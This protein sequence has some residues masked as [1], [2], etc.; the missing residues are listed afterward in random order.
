[1]SRTSKAPKAIVTGAAGFIGSNTVARLLSK[2][3]QVVAI[4]NLSR[5]GAEVNLEWLQSL[6]LRTFIEGDVRNGDLMELVVRENADAEVL[7]HLAGQVAVTTS[8]KDPRS[9]FEHNILGTLNLLEACRLHAPETMFLFSSTNKVYGGLEEYDRHLDGMRY[10]FPQFPRGI[11]EELPLDFHSPYGCSKGAADQ[12]V[13]DYHRIYG[14]PTVVFRQSCIYGVRQMGVEDQGW[15]A[16]FLIAAL[17]GQEVTLFGDGNQVRDLLYIDDLVDLYLAAIE[18]RGQAAGQ[19]YNVGGGASNSLSLLEFFL[20]LRKEF[21]IEVRYTQETWRP[22]DQHYFVADTT[23][24]RVELG[25]VPQVGLKVGLGRLLEW[26][27]QNRASLGL[28]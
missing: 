16:W 18:R 25:W 4:D 8:V 5:V 27:R 15:V 12:Y 2:G 17:R 22:G 6:G 11:S 7:I 20:M 28:K 9:D 26:L 13:R 19:I 10:V 24:A 23:K 1:M 14:M 3:Y 21:E